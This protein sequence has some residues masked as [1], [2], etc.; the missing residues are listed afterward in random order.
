VCDEP[1]LVM[2]YD[3]HADS[4]TLLASAL[5]AA[6]PPGSPSASDATRA[7]L[8]AERGRA[9]ALRT[10]LA[11]G[12]SPPVRT[13]VSTEGSSAGY[14]PTPAEGEQPIPGVI[15]SGQQPIPGV[16]TSG[17]QPIPGLEA[18]GAA[19]P[20]PGA[21]PPL[22]LALISH[23]LDP[24]SEGDQ[25]CALLGKLYGAGAGP[26]AGVL[27]YYALLDD[28]RGEAPPAL[29]AWVLSADGGVQFYQGAGAA[30]GRSLNEAAA[31]LHEK[32]A[33]LAH[34]HT[35]RG[36]KGSAEAHAQQKEELASRGVLQEGDTLEQQADVSAELALLAQLVLHPIL[37]HLPE[38]A[39]LTLVPHA[40]LAIV[41]FAALPLPDGAPLIERHAISQ[42]QGQG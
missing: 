16:I 25:I 7:L 37:P 39:P 36:A 35:T 32:I 34:A 8:A 23:D 30:D 6:A 18:S 1:E 17:Q 21:A 28:T 4:F 42:G 19:T 20:L 41:P 26:E 14:H 11:L 15:T 3:D 38:G 9:G 40:P 27:V 2:L 22:D 13:E 24:I 12:P 29:C 5:L 31:D 10:L 33:L